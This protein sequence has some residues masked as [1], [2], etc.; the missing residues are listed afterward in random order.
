MITKYVELRSRILH[1]LAGGREY[2]SGDVAK[3]MRMT[4]RKQGDI[5]RYVMRWMHVDGLIF[6]RLVNGRAVW[7][8]KD[9][10]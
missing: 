6:R 8:A 7:S 9:K 4:G 2:K 1:L 5:V 10:T 3:A